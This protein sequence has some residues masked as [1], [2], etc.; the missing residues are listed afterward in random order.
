MAVPKPREKQSSKHS[1]NTATKRHTEPKES[2]PPQ[3]ATR[4]DAPQLEDIFPS[5]VLDGGPVQLQAL[6]DSMDA[7]FGE[8]PSGAEIARDF[9]G[10]EEDVRIQ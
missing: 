9:Q 4:R 2:Q 7:A 8:Q 6:R 5:Y 1:R 3:E 10:F